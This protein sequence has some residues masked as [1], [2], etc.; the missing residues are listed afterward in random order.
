MAIKIIKNTLIEP[1]YKTCPECGSVFTF[2]CDDIQRG[3]TTSIFGNEMSY[4][5]ILC[6]VCKY[7]CSFKIWE[8]EQCDLSKKEEKDDTN[9]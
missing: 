8:T 7:E 2:N 6:P 4:R 1:I 3:T 9:N 5:Y